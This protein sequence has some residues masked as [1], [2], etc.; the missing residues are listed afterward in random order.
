MAALAGKGPGLFT[1]QTDVDAVTP[2]EASD[3]PANID[4]GTE[5]FQNQHSYNAGIN[6]FSRVP[7]TL[8]SYEE[9]MDQLPKE[10]YF[11][12]I[13]VA[14]PTCPGES[15]PIYDYAN[16]PPSSN[17]SGVSLCCKSRDIFHPPHGSPVLV[18]TIVGY[19]SEVGLKP[20]QQAV[21][22]PDGKYYFF[23]DHK[24]KTTFIKDPRPQ[25]KQKSTVE[26]L[27][28]F[29]GGGKQHKSLPFETC[30]E[31]AV[32]NGAAERAAKKPH[33]FILNATGMIRNLGSDGNSGEDG[34]CGTPGIQGY[35][36]QSQ[37]GTGGDGFCG[38]CGE[39]GTRGDDG[40]PGSGVIL[41][42]SGSAEELHISGTCNA[43]ARLGGEDHQ[44]VVF[45]DCRGGDG[46]D[47]GKGGDGG[48]GG[49]GADGGKGATGGDGGHGGD[50]GMGG[51]GGDGGN[52]GNAGSG[53]SCIVQTVDSQLLMLVEANCK[54]GTAG[55]GGS[56]G[57]P[58]EGGR[59]G[60]GGEG[61]HVI[62]DV[63]SQENPYTL[64][65]RGKPGMTGPQG[66]WGEPG[67]DGLPGRDGGILWVVKSANGEVLHRAGTRYDAEVVSMNVST[68]TDNGI[69]EVNQRISVSNVTVT[70]SGG[71]PLPAGA[72]L[73]FPS[74]E[75][76]RFEPTV[77][78]MPELAPEES[79][80]VPITFHGR[81]ADE[82]P[83][84]APG[85]FVSQAH[86]APRIELLGRPFEKSILEQTLTVQYPI[87]LA[88]AL[89]KLN[90]GRGEVTTL[91]VG[92]EN[93]SGLPFGT[94]HS[95]RSVTVQIHM[96]S[97][98]IPLGVIPTNSKPQRRTNPVTA[99]T[100]ETTPSF[101][102]SYDPIGINVQITS[103]QP[104]ET[105]HIPIA[106]Q[107]DGRADLFSSCRWEADLYLKGKLIEYM[108]SE[109]RVSPAY[110]LLPSPSQLGDV[111]MVTSNTISQEE[112]TFWQKIFNTLEVNV[113]YWDSSYQKPLEEAESAAVT[114]ELLSKIQR[115]YSGKLILYPHCNLN[116]LPAKEIVTH[117]HGNESQ[118][119]TG[120]HEDLN[121]SMV[122]FLS[123][124]HS[125]SSKSLEDHF[126]KFQGDSKLMQ[127]LCSS[128]P[129]LEL[130][131]GVYS[132][133]HFLPPGTFISPEWFMK[134][135][136]KSTV[137]RFGKDAPSQ[138]IAVVGHKNTLQSAGSFQYSYGSLDVRLCPLL[139][140]C[141]F[142]CID[143]AGGN[144]TARMGADDPL[145]TPTS[146]DVPLAG[147]FGQVFLATLS[148]LPLHCK[149]NLLKT[150]DNLSTNSMR[151][152]LP[153]GLCLTVPELAAICIASEVA[154]EVLNCSGKTTRI[155]SLVEDI[156][157]QQQD[158]S[159]CKTST[160]SPYSTLILQLVNLI[161]REVTDRRKKVNS[162]K[163][164]TA[165][166]EIK[167]LCITLTE[168]VDTPH[169]VLL[170]PSLRVL[171]DR[172]RVLRTH[173]NTAS[174]QHYD[175]SQL[176]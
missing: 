4:T 135:A 109:V 28:H 77:F 64:T 32:I 79:F 143:G 10:F 100:E 176:H 142:Q 112:H 113:D 137:K 30:K 59:G 13:E 49:D 50:G 84:N 69:Y 71:L 24:E 167:K 105:M 2:D 65:L 171:Q 53:G 15:L 150:A 38:I 125:S 172:H 61:G 123:K 35:Q 43:V 58:G 18:P 63:P 140:S 156:Q 168:L 56:G 33:G 165:A 173:Q 60:F 74:S 107:L 117:F 91:E 42:I 57:K 23:L 55:N 138:A 44:E 157:Q 132:G 97:H 83:P 86:F 51:D 139:C 146:S 122:L 67:T 39:N 25:P 145:M 128:Q 12:D 11:P 29:Y 31:S 7:T 14:S 36:Y 90:V 72:K 152:H 129:S 166:R 1:Q 154:D 106:V 151:F 8:Q 149:V 164:S 85:A 103:I 121:S 131:P 88:F 111:L 6:S 115:F 170:L 87:K 127:H 9:V 37:G 27:E 75:T 20:H 26:T 153:N 73:F 163:I 94:C 101:T 98:L 22:D 148:G 116:K 126:M 160:P 34:E 134:R 104:G 45:V 5:L 147:N 130:P 124:S 133:R 119:E 136:E 16:P 21:W 114:N 96:D 52:G 99:V 3:G 159:P 54:A 19:G 144:M 81:I 118:K 17:T 120:F 169:Q 40:G 174:E 66:E 102:V 93:I 175:T 108:T 41:D 110:S 76:V 155:S 47:G 80:Q 48:R 68:S 95:R 162:T 70:N 89:S 141:N 78:T 161:K 92:V 158:S 82:P 62:A 46:R